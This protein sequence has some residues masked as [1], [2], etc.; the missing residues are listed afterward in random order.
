M[1]HFSASHG[2]PV[3]VARTSGY[4]LVDRRSFAPKSCSL[5]VL[6]SS[7][8]SGRLS[9]TKEHEDSARFETA[10]VNFALR[11]VFGAEKN[12]TKV[13]WRENRSMRKTGGSDT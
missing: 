8:A 7:S 10:Y 13:R 3:V 6:M 4:I 9:C 2:F 1:I 11:T 12:T 5:F